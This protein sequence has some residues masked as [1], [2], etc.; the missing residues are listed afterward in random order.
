MILPKANFKNKIQI[1]IQIIKYKKRT[2]MI[3]REISLINKIKM[4]VNLKLILW[5][6]LQKTFN[7]K[8]LLGKVIS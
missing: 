3:T 2:K 5:Q 7:F 4:R 6:S 1:K 8:T